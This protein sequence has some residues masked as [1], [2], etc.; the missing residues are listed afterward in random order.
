MH[1]MY[2]GLLQLL[3]LAQFVCVCVCTLHANVFLFFTSQFITWCARS[4]VTS[5]WISFRNCLCILYFSFLF[6]CFCFCSF[7]FALCISVHVCLFLSKIWWLHYCA[8]RD[9]FCFCII[10]NFLFFFFGFCSVSDV[11]IHIFTIIS[12]TQA[13]I[14]LKIYTS[15]LY[16]CYTTLQSLLLYIKSPLYMACFWDV[17]HEEKIFCELLIYWRNSDTQSL[18][19]WQLMKY[20]ICFSKTALSFKCAWALGPEKNT[21]V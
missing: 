13:L 18:P 20:I 2:N 14:W 8:P 1:I 3:S 15:S 9:K 5:F 10:Y 12:S 6:F 19:P 16:G 11:C 17:C 7:L 21:F 4:Q